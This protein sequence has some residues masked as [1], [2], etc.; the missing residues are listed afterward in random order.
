MT[1]T[2]A[3]GTV[4]KPWS[5]VEEELQNAF[6]T[7]EINGDEFFWS[8]NFLKIFHVYLLVDRRSG[9]VNLTV[10]SWIPYSALAIA[11]GGFAVVSVVLW[12][13]D[14]LVYISMFA[15]LTIYTFGCIPGWIIERFVHAQ[16]SE[17]LSINSYHFTPVLL[18]PISGWSLHVLRLASN[19]SILNKVFYISLAVVP[20]L[21]TVS[22]TISQLRE[23]RKQALLIFLPILTTLPV[24]VGAGNLWILYTAIPETAPRKLPLIVGVLVF[25]MIVL[26][27]VYSI[28]C[29]KL[30]VGAGSLPNDPVPTT[31]LRLFWGGVFVTVN[32][33]FT[34]IVIILLFGGLGSALWQKIIPAVTTGFSLI[35]Y[36]APKLLSSVS[37]VL[38]LMPIIAIS[39]LWGQ[40]LI[41]L[42]RTRHK[43]FSESSCFEGFDEPIPV[44]VIQTEKLVARPIQTISNR[45]AVLL[46]SGVLETLQ[47]DEVRAVIAHERY[48]LENQDL[49]W[50]RVAAL[51]GFFLGGKNIL[52]ALYDFPKIEMEADEF[53]AQEVGTQPLIR[54]LHRWE[55]A[56]AAQKG[57]PT[58]SLGLARN[59]RK[60]V[61]RNTFTAVREILFGSIILRHAHASTNER[62]N[63]LSS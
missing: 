12:T 29:R 11:T 23:M 2:Q 13:T 63:M 35:G 16:T 19:S 8:Y 10:E 44:R 58:A 53:A 56:E 21:I 46:S 47:E 6:G 54:A 34:A 36:P 17:I 37:I 62:V 27:V 48:H 24:L 5:L 31:T 7:P 26:A 41:R 25:N 14:F 49:M 61:V 15:C 57:G 1:L 32:I 43:L 33:C 4:T 50:T 20:F 40:H 22:M 38:L 9:D 51:L 28:L 60:N 18:I 45:K 52:V 42:H 59:N 30:V 55:Q 39:L 3:T